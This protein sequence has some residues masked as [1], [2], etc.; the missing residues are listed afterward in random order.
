MEQDEI[1][2]NVGLI[3]IGKNREQDE[4]I[5]YIRNTLNL[6][7]EGSEL[8]AVGRSLKDWAFLRKEIEKVIQN[9]KIH[10]KLALLD[11]NSIPDKNVQP[12][13]L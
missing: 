6:A 8:I 1:C 5:G 13:I 11:E 10:F 4:R 3:N 9:K 7:R 12:D 2:D